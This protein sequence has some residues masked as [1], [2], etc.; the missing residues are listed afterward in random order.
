MGNHYCL[1]SW[2]LCLSLFDTKIIDTL[3]LPKIKNL[4]AYNKEHTFNKMIKIIILL[5]G[6]QEGGGK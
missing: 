1:C 4:S 5:S 2:N 6:P 3:C